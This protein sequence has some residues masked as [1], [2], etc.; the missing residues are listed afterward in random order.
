MK[1]LGVKSLLA[2]ALA[3]VT[4]LSCWTAVNAEGDDVTAATGGEYPDAP[5]LLVTEV[6][7]EYPSQGYTYTEVFNNSDETIDISK[8]TFFY[9]Y[10]SGM[11][12]GRIFQ[13][14]KK[15]GE[16]YFELSTALNGTEDPDPI[17]LE[18]G[19]SI[20]FWQSKSSDKLDAFN[21][22]YGT[23]Y[24]LGDGIVRV[25]Y[26]GI[27]PSSKRG[28]FFGKDSDSIVSYAWSNK[29]GDQVKSNAKSTIQ[30]KYNGNGIE[31]E[32]IGVMDPTPGTVS[33][34][35]VPA[36]RVHEA[37]SEI[38]ISNVK[39]DGTGP[40]Q[41]S[42]D[43]NADGSAHM[44][45][46]YKQANG[47]YADYHQIDMSRTSGNTFTAEI[48]SEMIYGNEVTWY[49]SAVSGSYS[50]KSEE[51]TTAVTPQEPENQAPLFVTEVAPVGG[52]DGMSYFEVYNQSDTAI[53]LSYYK[54][55]YYYDYPNRTASQSGK[56][57][58]IEGD[59]DL[60]LAPGKTMVYWLN[61]IGKDV[62]DF[63]SYYGTDLEL[64]K[65]IVKVNYAGLHAT[66][67]RWIR[68]GTN[69]DDAFTVCGFNQSDD[70]IVKAKGS[71]EFASPHGK[72]TENA[73]IPVRTIA[74]A[75][76][77]T[78]EDW[79]IS[80][81]PVA[82]AGYANYPKDDGKAPTLNV[83]E[84]ENLPVPSS[85]N[86][87]ET[88]KVM[89]DVD[90]LLGATSQDRIDAFTDDN[91]PGGTES[92]KTRP[93]ILGTEIFYKLD[94]DT[95]WTRIQERKQWR[96][97]H[98][99]MQIP[100]DVTFGH[101][102]ITFKVRSYN[103]Y[104]YSET[105]ESTVMINAINDT[106][107]AVRLNTEDGEILTG[108]TT[109]TA[110]DG[111]DNQNTKITVDGSEQSLH[112]TLEDGAYFMLEADGVNNYFKDAITAPYGDNSREIITILG[113]W[114]EEPVTHAVHID[115]KFFTYNSEN[116]SYDVTLTVWAG[117]QATPFEEIYDAVKGA[118]HEDMTLT[119]LQLRLANGNT[120]LPVSISP[121]NTKTNTDTSYD[122]VHTVGDSSGMETHI[123]VS[124]SIPASEVTAVGSVLDTTALA[125]GEHTVAASSDD[126]QETTAKVIIDNTKPVIHAG[127]ENNATIYQPVTLNAGDLAED[128]NGVKAVSAVLDNREL[129]LPYT[130]VPRELA[131]GS[132]TLSIMALD[133]AGNYDTQEITFN[134][135]YTDPGV[136]DEQ[137]DAADTTATLTVN[138]ADGNNHVSFYEG[139]ALSMDNGITEGASMA[140]VPYSSFPYH[141][142]TISA[143]D[144]NADDTLSVHWKGEASASDEDHPIT[145]YAYNIT[146]N[147]WDFVAEANENEIN[148]KF[149]A[150]SYV[151]DGSATIVVQCATRGITPNVSQT[152]AS[153]AE[154]A[155][156]LSAASTSDWDGFSVPSQYDFAFAWETDTQYYAESF[157]YHY[158]NMNQWIVDNADALKIRYV[159]HTGDIVDDADMTGEWQNADHSMKI[160]DDAGMP[161][162]VLAG[163]HDVFAGM[164][165]YGNYWQYFGEQR[166][167]G[168]PWYGGS[169]K[170]NL[171]HYDLLTENGEDFLIL[172]MSW[173]I[174]TDEIN[175]INSVLAQYP[176]R[177]AILCFH[178]YLNVTDPN[179]LLDYNGQLIQS[180]VVAKNKNVIAV[181]NGHYHG[182]SVET[183]TYDD[184]GDGTKDRTV[185]QICTDYQSDPEGGSEYIKF[186]Y[187]DLAGNKVYVNSYSPYRNDYNY[188][189]SQKL[190]ASVDGSRAVNQDALELDYNVTQDYSG[191]TRTLTTNEISAEVL[192]NRLIGEQDGVQ[193]VVNQN[194]TGLQ[195]ETSYGWYCVITNDLGGET[196][197]PV[198]TFTTAQKYVP[199]DGGGSGSGNNTSNDTQDESQEVMYRLYNPNSG[200]H[201]Y[202][203]SA[204]EKEYL[205]SLGWKD[206]G[207]GWVA[208][209]SSN[210][211][212]YRL[213]NA[214]GGE[215][216]YTMDSRER[217]ALVS[218]GWSYE[219]IGWYSDE[220]K[221]VAV[222]RQY[223]PNAF[224][225]N[226]NY[227]VSADEKNYLVSLGWHDEGISWYAVSAQ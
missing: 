3:V 210:A 26:S 4:G 87:G 128:A 189:D 215:H 152:V 37:D 38:S 211:P 209:T 12:S 19:K 124:F 82:F 212:V 34:D 102:K 2:L 48:P 6:A 170:N 177:K 36:N 85:I 110:N 179:N 154:A 11:G 164:E 89:Y 222:Y 80:G 153:Q 76:P 226:H 130:I 136:N 180:E 47:D 18:S 172:Y 29:T 178:R 71:L 137:N 169:Y 218:V 159:V 81:N 162:G 142:Y 35:Q 188:Y 52:K 116:D 103:V 30:Y 158:D 9:V 202:T 5:A 51:T 79:Q 25:D 203:A 133:N 201:F 182:A 16:T 225:N 156:G 126:S 42:A 27:H 165:R 96:L 123:D 108:T 184:D 39:A 205:V 91:R 227:T 63:N 171:G 117:G 10:E 121:D 64:G 216:H 174:Y 99:L 122:A 192:S 95:D 221:R 181:L 69:E 100:G 112:K 167:T 141:I 114:L 58:N 50:A 163:N 207:V 14:R 49:V 104:R 84:T 22:Y 54:I 32:S 160:F 40:L 111:S 86:E 190:N 67:P 77:G 59:F 134:T 101:K 147:T 78:V 61:N 131:A 1:K 191:V 68:F 24:Q 135:E 175:W 23:D 43:L 208:P 88:L 8:Y 150:G 129:E 31:S 73:S 113:S 196:V 120:Y 60:T 56:V 119:H 127:I 109:I 41:I 168:K 161:Y 220:Q 90:L 149:A 53:N 66:Q 74:K 140:S 204:D 20:L 94:D 21:A 217:D 151:S 146:T 185:Y 206:E 139:K 92:L 72:S 187:F 166:F 93:Y 44:V 197:T 155:D 224:A 115:N 132:H 45:L 106:N 118:N 33:S 46:H 173:D 107:G 138:V 219:G 200:E 98:Y 75:T 105:P 157:P 198:Q 7:T 186:L 144:V 223:N 125:D 15:N 13:A 28:Y 57:W 143:G 183:D 199:D 194:W 193:G 145:M 83:C 176:D 195:P 148:A 65:D 17:M 55:L 214:N 213:Y 97:G 70:E 62:S